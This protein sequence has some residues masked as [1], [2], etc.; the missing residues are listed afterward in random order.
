MPQESSENQSLNV[1]RNVMLVPNGLKV[2]YNTIDGVFMAE[3]NIF[4]ASEQSQAMFPNLLADI[5]QGLAAAKAAAEAM[6][7]A[8][9]EQTAA[10]ANVGKAMLE[11]ESAPV[12]EGE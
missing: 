5:A 1:K 7:Q 12:A 10:Q 4:G 9:E 11:P 3:I 8:E 6:K 2:I